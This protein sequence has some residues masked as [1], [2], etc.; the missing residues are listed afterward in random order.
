M[1]KPSSAK[2]GI[3]LKFS[4]DD[5]EIII[6][7]TRRDFL[8]CGYVLDI[9]VLGWQFD[10]VHPGAFAALCVARFSVACYLDSRFSCALF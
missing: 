6:K 8:I 2:I 4:R 1:L 3:I 9:S 7:E 10:N 5:V